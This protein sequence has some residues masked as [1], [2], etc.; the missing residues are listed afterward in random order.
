MRLSMMTSSNGNIFRIAGSLWGNPPVTIGFSSQRPVTRSFDVSFDLWLKKVLSKQSR[1][2][3]FVTTSYSLWRHCNKLAVTYTAYIF[4]PIKAP[5]W[6]INHIIPRVIYG[7]DWKE[8]FQQSIFIST[9][10]FKNEVTPLQTHWIYVTFS[11]RHR[12]I[13]A[14]KCYRC[15]CRYVWRA[16]MMTALP[17]KQTWS[18]LRINC[19]ISRVL[20]STSCQ[21]NIALKDF[22]IFP[23][24]FLLLKGFYI[25]LMS[26]DDRC[27]VEQSSSDN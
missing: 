13:P 22:H 21:W 6:W 25:C 20:I 4:C 9:A 15:V 11:L 18:L 19:N 1:R 14:H 12:Y 16:M 5:F 17:V 26:N 2:R 23:L 10:K 7:P 24:I 3:W 27:G 8:I